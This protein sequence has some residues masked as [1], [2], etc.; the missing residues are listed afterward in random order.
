M[1]TSPPLPDYLVRRYYGWKATSYRENRAWLRRLAEDGQRP[2]EMVI[3]CC[4]SRLHVDPMFGSFADDLFVHRNIAGLVPRAELGNT[5][6]STSASVEFAVTILR[7]SHILIL[8]HSQ[9]GGIRTAL[10]MC[11]C[12]SSELPEPDSFIGRW[13]DALRPV[14]DGLPEA[15]GPNEAAREMERRSVV[16]S[17]ENLL[18]YPKVRQAIE[19]E[20]LSIHGLWIDI[21]DGRLETY[22]PQRDRFVEV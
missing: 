4:D 2:R 5:I 17:L 7:V 11:R 21:A 15:L 9:C 3:T 10:D 8:G 13:L 19:E 6:Q 1:K 16:L 14:Y 12:A 18:T 20:A 22:D